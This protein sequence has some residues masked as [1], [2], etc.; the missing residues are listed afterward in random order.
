MR[1][2]VLCLLACT[3]TLLATSD[4]V[5]QSDSTSHRVIQMALAQENNRLLLSSK[6]E[7]SNLAPVLSTVEAGPDVTGD[8]KIWRVRAGSSS[9]LIVEGNGGLYR[10]GGFPSFDLVELSRLLGRRRPCSSGATQLAHCLAVVLDPNGAIQ[11]IQPLLI[12]KDSL[13]LAASAAWVQVM[14][15][16]WPT[17]TLIGRQEGDTLVVSTAFT[18]HLDTFDQSWTAVA[19]AFSF[20]RGEVAALS[21]R[22]GPP[23]SFRG[24]APPVSRTVEP[25]RE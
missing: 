22:R 1:D 13:A 8:L 19:Y 3:A 7:G 21:V 17:D 23:F 24:K 16:D 20:R 4:S 11:V 15:S 18:R 5:A 2:V 6:T 12:P 25:K 9:Y 10:A 14:P